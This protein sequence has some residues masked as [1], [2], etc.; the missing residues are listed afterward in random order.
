MQAASRAS[1]N[2]DD[3]SPRP[4]ARMPRGRALSL[5]F[6][7]AAIGY[8]VDLATKQLAVTRLETGDYHPVVGQWFG[9]LLTS[10]SGAAFSLGTS[11]TLVLTVVAAVAAVVTLTV[12]LRRLRSTGW[13]WGLGFLLA[14][15]LGNLTDRLV[16]EPE[17]FRGHVVDFLRFPNFPVFNVADVCINAAAAFIIIQSVRGMR[18]DGRPSDP[19][20]PAPAPAPASDSEG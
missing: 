13:A 14:G 11:Y 5:F 3:A 17:P 4:G 2:D 10:N 1:L 8:A 20:S 18:V 15:I 6:S 7:V 9:L 19:P 16:R 12:A